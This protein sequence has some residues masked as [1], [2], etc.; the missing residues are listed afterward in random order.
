MWLVE[1][2][3]YECTSNTNK[4]K[5]GIMKCIEIIYGYYTNKPKKQHIIYKI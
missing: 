5:V 4:L 2:A 3:V 1:H